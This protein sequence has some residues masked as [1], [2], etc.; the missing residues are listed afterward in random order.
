MSNYISEAR[1]AAA[2]TEEI[3]PYILSRRTEKEVAG[4]DGA[5]LYTAYYRADAPRGT[6]FLLHGFSENAEKY[7]ELIYYC[8]QE[9]LSVVAYDH[10]GHGRS[11][12]QAPVGIIHV[13][14][15]A[16]Y[17]KDFDA[18]YAAYSDTVP[19]PFYLLAHSMGGA[20]GA[21][22]L[23]RYPTRFR[24]AVLVAPMLDLTYR[25]RERLIITLACR[26][27]C[28]VGKRKH[29][30]PTPK[31]DYENE[32]FENSYFLSLPRF[33]ALRELRRT[34]PKMSGGTPSIAWTAAALGVRRQILA[35]GAA[36]RIKTPVLLFSAENETLVSN[37]AHNAFMAR[38]SCGTHRV[39]AGAR[40]E[41][42]FSDDPR[43]FP[44]LD[45][46]F[47]FFK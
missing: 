4:F 22:L 7:R 37:E 6:V 32:P 10:R 46:I 38:L 40:H 33:L 16:D 3:L 12:R 5:P 29:S 47:A 41:I 1:F 44:V 13:G 11:A 34:D 14:R 42:L 8:L 20:V 19:A 21:L 43:L 36:E 26:A 23:E 30:V 15:F 25:G 31:K 45:E 2:L 9:N 24:R 27:A 18:V 39:V 17:I 35:R 28:L